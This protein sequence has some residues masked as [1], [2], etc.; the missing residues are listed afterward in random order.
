[1]NKSFV[2]E[3]LNVNEAPVTVSFRDAGA[4]LRFVAGF[5]KVNENSAIGT[6][7]GIV[8][9]HD[10]DAG[11]ML[12]FSLDDDAGGRFKV[13]T[14]KSVTCNATKSIP[15]RIWQRKTLGLNE[16]LCRVPNRCVLLR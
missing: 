15:V 4:Q 5:P 6:V 14:G 8:E 9:A 1:M 16:R 11:Q 2:I 10:A 3:V 13:A 12:A 7:V